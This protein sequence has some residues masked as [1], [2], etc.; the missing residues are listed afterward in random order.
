MMKAETS[1]LKANSSNGRS[2]KI[3]LG[4]ARLQTSDPT[5]HSHLLVAVMIMML[6]TM[7]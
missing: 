6:Q 2:S 5:S 3:G 4:V 1:E 7:W